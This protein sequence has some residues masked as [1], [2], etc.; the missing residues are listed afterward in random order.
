[1]SAGLGL[2][3]MG[4]LGAT[5]IAVRAALVRVT[6]D[7]APAIADAHSGVGVRALACSFAVAWRHACR[8]ATPMAEFFCHTSHLTPPFSNS[9][10]IIIICQIDCLA[11]DLSIKII[12]NEST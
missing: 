5:P 7:F 1:M 10:I 6:T 9:L 4:A 8:F 11:I 3:G 12:Y 2:G